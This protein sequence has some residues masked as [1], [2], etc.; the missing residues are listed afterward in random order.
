MAWHLQIVLVA[1][2]VLLGLLLAAPAWWPDGR[3]ARRFRWGVFLL[4]A[5]PGLVLANLYGIGGLIELFSRLGWVDPLVRGG[6]R[7]IGGVLAGYG[8]GQAL[9][10]RRTP[11][12]VPQGAAGS[13]RR[14]V[15]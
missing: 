6:A 9:A 5:L 10:A 8:L 7:E 12:A 3:P 15:P 1:L 2:L 13:Q 14:G 4:C 11:V